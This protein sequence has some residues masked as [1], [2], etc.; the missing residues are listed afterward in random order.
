MKKTEKIKRALKDTE[1][2]ETK[3]YPKRVASVV[4]G[5]FSVLS[6][7]LALLGFL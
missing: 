1:L 6:C 4:L 5:A 3:H 2:A 7:V